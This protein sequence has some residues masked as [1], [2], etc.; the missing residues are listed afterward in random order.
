LAGLGVPVRGSVQ[1]PAMVTVLEA[2]SAAPVAWILAAV[3]EVEW[4]QELGLDTVGKGDRRIF[5]QKPT[6]KML[7]VR[8]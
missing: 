3:P 1:E 6:E 8:R 5:G 7:T 2:P 4:V